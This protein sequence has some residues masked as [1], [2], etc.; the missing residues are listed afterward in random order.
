ME[1]SE[2]IKT[3]ATSQQQYASEEEKSPVVDPRFADDPGPPPYAGFPPFF[4]VDPDA[5][6]VQ[7]EYYLESYVKRHFKCLSEKAKA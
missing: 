4:P 3:A 7:L 1:I 2:E 6:T 5:D